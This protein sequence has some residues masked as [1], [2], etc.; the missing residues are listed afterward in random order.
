[1]FTERLVEEVGVVRHN[2]KI[3]NGTVNSK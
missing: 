2:D 1:V 3:G